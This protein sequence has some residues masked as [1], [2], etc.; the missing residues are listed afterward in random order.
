MTRPSLLAG[1]EAEMLRP[2]VTWLMNTNHCSGGSP[3]TTGYRPK[4]RMTPFNSRGFA[5]SNISIK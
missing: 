2:G 3:A 1:R 5:A 4:T